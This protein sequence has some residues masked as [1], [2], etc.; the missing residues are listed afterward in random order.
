MPRSYSKDPDIAELEKEVDAG[1]NRNLPTTGQQGEMGVEAFQG[2]LPDYLK[3]FVPGAGSEQIRPK[4]A[5][6][7]RLKMLQGMSAEVGQ[8]GAKIGDWYHNVAEKTVRNGFLFIPCFLWRNAILWKHRD[9]GGGIIARATMRDFDWGAWDPPNAS[10]ETLTS[11]SR[12][13][14]KGNTAATVKESGLLDF[15][16]SEPGDRTAAPVATEYLNILALL[17]D[18]LQLSPCVISFKGTS[19]PFVERWLMQMEM[20]RRNGVKPPRQSLVYRLASRPHTNKRG[21][22]FVVPSFDGKGFASPELYEAGKQY[23]E[24]FKDMGFDIEGDAEGPDEEYGGPVPNGH[25]DSG[26]RY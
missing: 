12:Q 13:P 22:T 20:V 5:G 15:G 24:S 17:P 2:P 19:L 10:F 9:L 25:E 8:G 11:K 3:D 14:L 16:T 7:P 1:S 26:A 23:W 6:M 4:S 21:Q 18:H